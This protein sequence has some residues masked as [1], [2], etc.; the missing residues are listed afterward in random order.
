MCIRDSVDLGE[1]G[2]IGKED[3]GLYHV[4]KGEVRLLED[5]GEIGHGLLGLDGVAGL[6]HRAGGR[7][8]RDLTGNIEEAVG[9]HGLRI[10]PDGLG[11]SL[12]HI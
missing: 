11:L 12:I 1:M 7:V 10:G 2:H 8:D 4:G 3:G 9:L 6:H 5:G